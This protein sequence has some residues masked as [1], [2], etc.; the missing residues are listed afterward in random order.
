MALAGAVLGGR[1]VLEQQIGKGGYG[2]VWHAT[3]TVL[4][5]PVAVKLLHSRYAQ[6]NDAL[7]RFRTEA[8][9]AGAL[10]HENIA[11]VYD[12]VEPPDG[13][14]PYLVMELVDGPSLEA[15][16]ADGPLDNSRT[17]DIVAQAAAGLQAAHAAGMVHR[18]VKPANLLLAPGGTVKITDFGIAHTVGSVQVTAT[19]EL[20]GTPGYLAPERVTGEPA[21]PASDLYSLGM[22]AYECLAGAPPFTGTALVVAL[23]HRDRPLPPLPPS[24]TAGVGAFV[25]R[26]TAKDPAN[27]LGSA[28]EAAVWAGLLRDGLGA[29]PA[30]LPVWPGSSSGPRQAVGRVRRRTFLAY[31]CVAVAAVV[32]IVLA[33]VI[34]FAATPHRASAQP[35]SSPPVASPGTGLAARPSSRPATSPGA[36]PLARLSPVAQQGPATDALAVTAAKPGR[37]HGHG[38]GKGQGNAKGKGKGKRKGSDAGP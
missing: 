11:Q 34:G 21:T 2:E 14:P 38:H 22:V 29:G 19:G 7:A 23:A 16:L 3:D 1:Y 30:T 13:Q 27:R 20:I 35:S 9:H 26:L 10:S 8:R 36:Q 12:Y 17:M 28:A 6:R 5:R 32:V 24:V 33:S 25:L 18:D 15:V 31:A 37:A 4:S